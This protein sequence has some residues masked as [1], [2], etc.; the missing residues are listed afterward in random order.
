MFRLFAGRVFGKISLLIS[1]PYGG[2]IFV[3]LVYGEWY[4]A[5]CERGFNREGRG[6]RP[7]Y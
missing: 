5:K 2:Y 6:E 7:V 4:A 3:T 1:S